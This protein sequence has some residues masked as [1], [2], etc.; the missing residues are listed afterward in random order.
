[1]VV[2]ASVLA[3]ALGAANAIVGVAVHRAAILLV[4]LLRMFLRDPMGSLGRAD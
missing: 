1:M 3:L 2:D 4:R